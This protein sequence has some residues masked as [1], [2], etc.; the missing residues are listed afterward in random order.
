MIRACVLGLSLIVAAV[1]AAAQ[2]RFTS[3]ADF[4][5]NPFVFV[6]R[7]PVNNGG[8]VAFMNSAPNTT[9]GAEGIRLGHGGAARTVIAG[10]FFDFRTRSLNDAG[11]TAAV[12]QDD[13]AVYRIASNGH[14]TLI[15]APED[16]DPD[17]A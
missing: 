4:P 10:G 1:P 13:G 2:Y 8:W 17:F 16:A 12:N 9:S 5:A 3:I 6:Q 15:A 14:A 11:Q 7:P